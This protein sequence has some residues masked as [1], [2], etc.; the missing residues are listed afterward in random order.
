MWTPL[1]VSAVFYSLVAAAAWWRPEGTR[2]FLGFFFIA[3]GLGI[4]A[5]F[6]ILAPGAFVHMADNAYLSLSRE[7]FNGPFAAHPVLFMVP[8][9]VFETAVGVCLLMRGRP[10]RLGLIA[11]TVFLL[12]ITLVGVEE[13]ANPILAVVTGYLATRPAERSLRDVVRG[14][15]RGDGGHR[16]RA[17]ESVT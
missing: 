7:F 17:S 9:I 16:R 14:V 2:L 12:A 6:T 11:A 15:R 13:L 4:N 5:A 10:V 3:C 8:V 1:I